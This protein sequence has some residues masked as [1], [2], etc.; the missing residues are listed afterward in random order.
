MP[1]PKL[2][3]K[4]AG[5][6][7]P[8]HLMWWRRTLRTRSVVTDWNHRHNALFIH[9]PKTAG[10][11][12]LS[13]FGAPAV[14]DTHAPARAYRQ[15]Y[16]GLYRRAYK[17]TVVRN[18]WDRFASAFH[19]L[20]SGTDWPM[21]RAWADAHIGD[22][23]FAAFTRGLRRPLRRAAVTAERFFWPQTFWLGGPGDAAGVDEVFHY[24]TLE[25]A[26]ALLS[27]RFDIELPVETPR[28]RR[29]ERPDFRLL[30]DDEMREIV[31]RLYRD[32]IAALGYTFEP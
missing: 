12:L 22:L 11:T 10:T 31:A 23:D 9:I 14:F 3:L 19:F 32:D 21:Q 18:P 8:Y 6:L 30:Y 25:K 4:L 27:R 15:A 1:V 20:K 7:Y 16:P 28:L 29:V 2:P 24:E 17:F 26:L 5:L 13:A